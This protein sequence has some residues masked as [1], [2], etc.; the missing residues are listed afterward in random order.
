MPVEISG[1]TVS[2]IR[3][4][5]SASISKTRPPGLAQQDTSGR[6]VTDTVSLTDTAAY[7]RRL[8]NTLATLP[9]VDV[10]RTDNIKK[11]LAD[12]SFVIDPVRV[13]DKLLRFESMFYYRAA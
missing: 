9:V 10:Q 5:D 4:I 11:A 1:K 2:N 7:L 12:G 6:A 3:A 8:E 13:A